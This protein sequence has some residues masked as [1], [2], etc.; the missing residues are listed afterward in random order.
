MLVHANMTLAHPYTN[1]SG[2][3][4]NG[5]NGALAS[6]QGDSGIVTKKMIPKQNEVNFENQQKPRHQVFS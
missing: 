3:S 4:S 2:V 5:K 1:G 6:D